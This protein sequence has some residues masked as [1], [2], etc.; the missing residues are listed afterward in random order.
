[1]TRKH[2]LILGIVAGVV[3]L[4]W[5]RIRPQIGQCVNCDPETGE[6]PVA[7][8][9]NQNPGGGADPR[10]PLDTEPEIDPDFFDR[11]DQE[12]L[13]DCMAGCQRHLPGDRLEYARCLNDCNL[14]YG[15]GGDA[16]G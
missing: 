16:F 13:Y 6:P 8:G 10:P 2:Y 7:G 1:M 5:W 3:G 11:I 14:H 9:G 15:E 12:R 4:W